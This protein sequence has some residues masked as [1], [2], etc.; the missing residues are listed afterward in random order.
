MS[1][2]KFIMIGMVIGS[3]AGG[4]APMLFG[5]DS[6]SASLKRNHLIPLFPSSSRV[7]T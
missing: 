2:N 5:N 1:K 6:I 4:C 3:V 7:C